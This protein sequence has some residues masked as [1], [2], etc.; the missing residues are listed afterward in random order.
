MKLMILP[1]GDAVLPSDVLTVEY[2][3]SFAGMTCVHPPRVCVQTKTDRILI[4]CESEDEAKAV[5]DGII[6]GVNEAL[7][8]ARP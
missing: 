4:R 8:E 5:R 7:A 2:F 6:A 3:E 1:N